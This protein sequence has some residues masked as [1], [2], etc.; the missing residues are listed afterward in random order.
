MKINISWFLPVYLKLFTME[1]ELL[2]GIAEFWRDEREKTQIEGAEMHARVLRRFKQRGEKSRKARL[3]KIKSRQ[4]KHDGQ[5]ELDFLDTN[6]RVDLERDLIVPR[7]RNT[8]RLF[9]LDELNL[10]RQSEL[11]IQTSLPTFAST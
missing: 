6:V 3:R 1:E 7:A 5:R 4:E 8:Y 9:G 10:L 2:P 11:I